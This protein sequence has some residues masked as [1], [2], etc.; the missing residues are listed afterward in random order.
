MWQALPCLVHDLTWLSTGSASSLL[1]LPA[2]SL[3]LTQ[4]ESPAGAKQGYQG[5]SRTGTS[6]CPLCS[7]L[8]EKGAMTA[9][10]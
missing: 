8:E 1:L 4:P 10:L 5:V 6:Q 9:M 2:A 7:P 3:T